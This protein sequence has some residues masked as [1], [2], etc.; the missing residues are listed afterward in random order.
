MIPKVIHYCCFGRNPLSQ[1]AQKCIASW[2]KYLPDYEIK[3]WNEDN[4]DINFLKFTREAYVVKKYAFV[5]DVA[6]LYALYKE[7]GVYLDTDVEITKSLSPMLNNKSFLGFEA[8]ALIGT[9]VIGAEMKTLWLRDILEQYKDAYF[10][11]FTGN[12]NDVP[13]TIRITKY[14]QHFGLVRNNEEQLL[15]NGVQ[16]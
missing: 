8:N 12:L 2:L 3:E 16:K 13:N 5:S 9:G 14:M 1:S 7:G 4:F 11:F 6:R 10:I 15:R